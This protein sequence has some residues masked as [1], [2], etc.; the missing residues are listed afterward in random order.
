MVST[1]AKIYMITPIKPVATK[2]KGTINIRF[3]I[4]QVIVI[5]KA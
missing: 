5:T 1:L 3:L 2:Y 4:S